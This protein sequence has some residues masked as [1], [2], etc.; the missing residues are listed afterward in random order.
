MQDTRLLENIRLVLCNPTHAG[1]IGAVARAMK[2]MGLSRLYLVNPSH[3][4]DV[5]ATARAC[6]G[7]DI[8]ESAVVT[9]TLD[10]ALKGVNLIGGLTARQRSLS[11]PVMSLRDAA[12]RFVRQAEQDEVALIFGTEM[13]GLSN[14]ELEACHVLVHIPANPVYSSLNLAAAVQVVA[15]E[16]AAGYFEIPHASTPPLALF[17]DVER[18]YAHLEEVLIDIGFL[19]LDSPRKLMSRMRRLFARAGL[20][21]EEVLMLRGMLKA[22]SSNRKTVDIERSDD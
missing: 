22:L 9:E 19:S 18:F 5:D 2:T 17:E 6:G 4:P 7:Q 10:E 8:L 1:N 20:E 13:S 14:K 12:P 11:H 15:Y 21:K 16:I 3:F